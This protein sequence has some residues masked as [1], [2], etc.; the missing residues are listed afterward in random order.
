MTEEKHN[1]FNMDIC[2]NCESC[3]KGREAY[4]KIVKKYFE[5]PIKESWYE[6]GD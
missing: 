6:N 2:C 3:K 1:H 4:N 5:Q